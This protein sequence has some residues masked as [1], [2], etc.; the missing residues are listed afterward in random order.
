MRKLLF[1]IL[2]LPACSTMVGGTDGAYVDREGVNSSVKAIISAFEFGVPG[3]KLRG[4]SRNGRELVSGYHPLSGN[5]Y[6]DATE[7]EIRAFVKLTIL[8]DRRPYTLRVQYIVQ[9][10]SSTGEY[11]NVKYDNGRAR[12]VLIK[13]REH[14][15]SRPDKSDFIDDFRAF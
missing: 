4:R 6:D 8:G 9:R 5:Q 7:K 12:K 11:E 3:G 13:M 10:R 1:L 14:L 15:A 2:L